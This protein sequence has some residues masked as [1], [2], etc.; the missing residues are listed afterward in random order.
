M[1]F[2]NLCNCAFCGVVKI[3]T[4]FV[5]YFVVIIYLETNFLISIAKGQDSQA[6]HF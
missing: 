6:E 2:L 5:N 1:I 3:K 4:N